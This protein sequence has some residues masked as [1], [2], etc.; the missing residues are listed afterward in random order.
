VTA[1]AAE[2]GEPFVVFEG[3]PRYYSRFG[4]EDARRR[5]INL[6][7]PDWAPPTAGQMLRLGTIAPGLRGTVVY[8]SA[9]DGVE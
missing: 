4:F 7:L 2:A 9:F 5:G 1:S 6:P 8:T 3:D